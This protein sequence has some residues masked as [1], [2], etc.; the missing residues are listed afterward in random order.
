MTPPILYGSRESGH[1]YKVKLALTLLA[2][3]S[4]VPRGRPSRAA[5]RTAKRFPARSPYGEV[6]VLVDGDLSLAQSNAIL[7]HLDSED[8]QP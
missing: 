5:E 7:M 8:R 6:P 2:I 3:A 4:R 1:T